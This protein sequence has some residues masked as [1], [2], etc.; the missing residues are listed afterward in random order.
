MALGGGDGR[1]LEN[2]RLSYAPPQ[3]GKL[4]RERIAA[5]GAETAADA[6][7]TVDAGNLAAAA[8]QGLFQPISSSVLGE[9]EFMN[10]PSHVRV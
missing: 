9:N 3:G 1:A 8:G 6:Y 2:V 10:S 5:E 4:L 7:I